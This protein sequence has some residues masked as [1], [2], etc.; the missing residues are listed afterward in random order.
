MS[1]IFYNK[2]IIIL[3]ISF[4]IFSYQLIYTQNKNK[5]I[6][7]GTGDS[8]AVLRAIAKKFESRYPGTKVEVPDSI[9]S[10]GGIRST[11]E[12]LCDFGRVAR[13]IKE[14]EKKYQLNYKLFAYSPIVFVVNGSV[15]KINN[16]TYEQIISIY[17]GKITMWNELGGENTKIYIANREP[18]DSSRTILEKNLPGFNKITSFA[19]KII[20]T[21]P[22]TVEIIS[23]YENTIGYVPLSATKKQNLKI[24]KINGFSPTAKNINNG[25]YKIY[26]SLGI[27]WKG[28]LQGLA[29][30]FVEYLYIH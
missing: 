9:G 20:Y 8:Q 16:I 1:R 18:G 10:S 14:N 29:K 24:L 6:I 4:F 21:T 22:E 19:G 2:I 28:K 15:K 12:G 27:V 5:I 17:S 23:K 3:T 13:K 30:Q 7:A 25:S 11:A 26:V